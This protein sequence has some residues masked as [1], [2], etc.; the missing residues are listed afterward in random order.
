MEQ[1]VIELG[2]NDPEDLIPQANF[3]WY[4]NELPV[5]GP[6]PSQPKHG[7]AGGQAKGENYSLRMIGALID[8]WTG[9]AEGPSSKTEKS[10]VSWL[11]DKNGSARDWSL[12]SPQPIEERL[13]KIRMLLS[14]RVLF[15][16]ERPDI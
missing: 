1:D 6:M 9:Y 4:E 16:E 11:N 14:G 3:G 2:G 8:L 10:L 15:K 5:F 12:T 13:L 7:A